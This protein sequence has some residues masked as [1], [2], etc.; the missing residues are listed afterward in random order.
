MVRHPLL[1]LSLFNLLVVLALLDV[2][3]DVLLGGCVDVEIRE[4]L[5]QKTAESL[6]SQSEAALLDQSRDS[7][8]ALLCLLLTAGLH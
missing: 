1:L 5:L 4:T 7:D 8:F 2:L 3:E 6:V